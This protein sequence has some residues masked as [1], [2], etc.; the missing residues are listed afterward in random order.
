MSEPRIK[1]TGGPATHQLEVFIGE[2]DVTPILT[3]ITLRAH[4]SET[5]VKVDLSF[6]APVEVDVVTGDLAD[7]IKEALGL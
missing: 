4:V 7:K 5:A 2:L 3:D 6:L 1:I